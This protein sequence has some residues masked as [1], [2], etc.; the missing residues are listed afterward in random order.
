MKHPKLRATGFEVDI[1][2]TVERELKSKEKQD[3]KW[4]E[5]P[6]PFPKLWLSRFLYVL[7]T[8]RKKNWQNNCNTNRW[9]RSLSQERASGSS[10]T[11]R[12]NQCY[13]VF[14]HHRFCGGLCFINVSSTA[15]G[16]FSRKGQPGAP[17]EIVI[18][19]LLKN[20]MGIFDW[21]TLKKETVGVLRQQLGN[22]HPPEWSFMGCWGWTS[23]WLHLSEQLNDITFSPKSDGNEPWKTG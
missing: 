14:S 13:F 20:N 23:F 3:D 9:Q 2:R 19:L 7:Q 18:C 6:H 1:K 11:F 16:H 5:S 10:G 22:D 12:C 8:W 15:Q 21:P 4:A 17:S